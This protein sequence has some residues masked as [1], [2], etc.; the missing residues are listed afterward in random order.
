MNNE[1]NS[2]KFKILIG[3]LIVFL[4]VFGVYIVLFYNDSK[5]IVVGF[6]K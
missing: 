3:V 5:N 6:E 1:S 4:I 2:I